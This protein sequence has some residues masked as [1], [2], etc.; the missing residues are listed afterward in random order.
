MSDNIQR[1]VIELATRGIGAALPAAQSIKSVADQSLPL[2]GR[3]VSSVFSGR[4][5]RASKQQ[6]WPNTNL[7]SLVTPEES[8]TQADLGGTDENAM[9]L[10]RVAMD[11][12]RDVQD[13]MMSLPE[14]PSL[15]TRMKR[16]HSDKTSVASV[17]AAIPMTDSG[18]SQFSIERQS[19]AGFHPGREVVTRISSPALQEFLLREQVVRKRR[20][21]IGTVD[22]QVPFHQQ[23]PA[24]VRRIAEEHISRQED[25][26]DN[27]DPSPVLYHPGPRSETTPTQNSAVHER[28]TTTNNLIERSGQPYAFSRNQIRQELVRPIT[29]VSAPVGVNQKAAQRVVSHQRITTS[30]PLTPAWQVEERSD[31]IHRLAPTQ[32]DPVDL[33]DD[34]TLVSRFPNDLREHDQH[35]SPINL[36][37]SRSQSLNEL[38]QFSETSTEAFLIPHDNDRPSFHPASALTVQSGALQT[39]HLALRRRQPEQVPSIENPQARV[40]IRPIDLDDSERPTPSVSPL[41]SVSLENHGHSETTG[42]RFPSSDMEARLESMFRRQ[43]ERFKSMIKNLAYWL[44]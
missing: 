11:K 25:R 31:E 12:D 27:L 16:F 5:G 8:G 19:R 43:E 6:T 33:Q 21:Y 24:S 15:L 13:F 26:V 29:I 20:R 44:K 38:E 17:P 41:Q 7:L 37:K 32:I 2:R 34:T 36:H 35:V 30:S 18:E 3:G 14:E 40:A 39:N 9:R 4:F 22:E 1:I 23:D 28:F 42:F 10:F